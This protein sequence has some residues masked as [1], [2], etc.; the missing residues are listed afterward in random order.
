MQRK[1]DQ[2]HI[3]DGKQSRKEH[4]ARTPGQVH[5]RLLTL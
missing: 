3:G 2:M 4:R 5:V 1:E